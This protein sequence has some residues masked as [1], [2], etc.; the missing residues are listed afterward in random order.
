MALGRTCANASIGQ[1]WW[2]CDFSALVDTHALQ[3]PVHPS[4]EFAQAHLTDEG[5]ALVMAAE[6]GQEMVQHW[7][8]LT[9]IEKTQKHAFLH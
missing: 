1:V 3:T 6:A 5:F 9:V 8:L 7:K 4:D 2:D